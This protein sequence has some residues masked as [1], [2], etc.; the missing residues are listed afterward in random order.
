MPV[1]YPIF[2]RAKSI[3]QPRI[4]VGEK[5]KNGPQL[6]HLETERM[7]VQLIERR[8]IAELPHKA[9]GY[10]ANMQFRIRGARGRRCRALS[11]GK[12]FK[13]LQVLLEPV[14]RRMPLVAEHMEQVL[15][16][17]FPRA[18]EAFDETAQRF[19]VKLFRQAQCSSGQNIHIAHASGGLADRLDGFKQPVGLLLA[20]ESQRGSDRLDPPRL[21]AQPV[22]L[23]WRKLVG[24]PFQ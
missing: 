18:F 21:G 23:V 12:C 2:Y 7:H 16:L 22:H 8:P 20:R 15:E 13:Q 1:A 5:L 24:Q 17:V 10:R 4:E 6:F 9:G 14:A 19:V 11:R 3:Q